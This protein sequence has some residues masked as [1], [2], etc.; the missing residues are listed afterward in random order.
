MARAELKPSLRPASCCNVEVMNGAF[1]RSLVSRDSTDCTVNG[2][3]GEIGREG[4]G[5]GLVEVDHLARL[6]QPTGVGIEVAPAGH[7]LRADGVERAGELGGV[8]GRRRREPAREVPVAG[9]AE[10]HARP[11]TVD[12]EAR[13][14]ALHPSGRGGTTGPAAHHQRHLVPVEPVED[15]SPLLRL[16]QLHVEGARVLDRLLDRFPGDLVEDH[17]LHRHR[18]LEH[19]EH[20]PGDGLAL[21]VLIGGEVDL[22]RVLQRRLELADVLLRSVGHDV[23]GLEVVV[24][25]D[26]EPPDLRVG[27]RLR[28]LLRAPGKIADVP[29]ARLH[30]DA[31]ATEEAFDGLRLGRRFDDHE[32]LRHW[33]PSF[34]WSGVGAGQSARD[35]PRD[36][37]SAAGRP[38]RTQRTVNWTQSVATP[39]GALSSGDP[40]DEVGRDPGDPPP[41]PAKE[42]T[43]ARPSGNRGLAGLQC[44]PCST[45]CSRPSLP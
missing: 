34:G 11:L 5:R 38:R 39:K 42:P 17:P 12:D 40:A 14:H 32:G 24:D 16:D 33:F 22:A 8:G 10:G 2:D 30:R 31:V 9:R 43:E 44:G 35:R 18:G 28:G 41:G 13:G 20:V 45:A 7:A 29:V 6:Q 19:L 36:G 37:Q 3:V 1:G 26:P 4:R 27:H 25:V 15:P 23:D 21:A